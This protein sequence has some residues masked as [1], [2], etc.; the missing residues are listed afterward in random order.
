M[1]N[2]KV[3]RKALEMACKYITIMEHDWENKNN[4]KHRVCR[5]SRFISMAKRHMFLNAKEAL[6]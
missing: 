3:L 2:E 4:I 1:N 5:P 6:K